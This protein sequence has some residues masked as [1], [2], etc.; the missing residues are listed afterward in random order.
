M[1]L[2]EGNQYDEVCSVVFTRVI[3]EPKYKYI[4]TSHKFHE[5]TKMKLFQN[6]YQ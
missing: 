4:P 2:T 3:R 5:P 6:K 1:N